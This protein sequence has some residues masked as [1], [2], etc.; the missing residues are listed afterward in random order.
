MKT[1][2]YGHS[3]C[4]YKVTENKIKISVVAHNLFKF[5]FFFLLKELRVGIWKTR[6]VSIGGKN[7]TNIIFCKYGEQSHVY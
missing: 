1:V 2:G 5:D 4:N 6:D 3:Y 7:P